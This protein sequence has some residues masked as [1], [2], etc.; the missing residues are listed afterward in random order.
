MTA[1]H[2]LDLIFGIWRRHTARSTRL[3]QIVPKHGMNKDGESSKVQSASGSHKFD[4]F[5]GLATSK[6]S[7]TSG[8]S[9]GGVK[10]SQKSKHKKSKGGE[11]SMVLAASGSHNFDES[12]AA[13]N[14]STISLSDSG[15]E[16][17]KEKHKQLVVEALE[18]LGIRCG[19][20]NSQIVHEVLEMGYDV[21]KLELLLSAVQ[22]GTRGDGSL[23]NGVGDLEMAPEGVGG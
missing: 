12:L 9:T 13:S 3:V 1:R 8:L 21:D 5:K 17:R 11:S 4:K 23:K 20:E 14:E 6:A 2:P 10:S 16:P 7:G 15:V 19:E 18:A 22:L